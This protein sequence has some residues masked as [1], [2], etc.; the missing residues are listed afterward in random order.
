MHQPG[1]AATLGVG[2]V[3][4]QVIVRTI[5]QSRPAVV[6]MFSALLEPAR[7]DA[8]ARLTLRGGP[9]GYVVEGGREFEALDGS[10]TGALRSLRHQVTLHLMAARSDLVWLHA[11]AAGRADRA[12]LLTGQSGCGKST[13]ATRLMA[14]GYG[15]LGDDVIP[16]DPSTGQTHPFP[17]MPWVRVHPRRV[18]APDEVPGLPRQ[19]TP[20]AWSQASRTPARVALV[21]FPA[22]EPGRLELRP[23]PPLRG[24]PRAATAVR[25]LRTPAGTGGSHDL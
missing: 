7:I 12:I 14:L 20:L 13:L 23:V 25:G 24:G 5:A 11:A 10:L 18:V 16:F 6:E 4:R 2:S 22:Y 8:V 19:G 9:N 1:G 3:G 21:V 15:Y 17:V